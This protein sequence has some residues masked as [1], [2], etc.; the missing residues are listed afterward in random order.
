MQKEWSNHITLRDQRVK[1][2][3]SMK[4]HKLQKSSPEVQKYHVLAQ[5]QELIQNWIIASFYQK[6]TPTH[7][8]LGK[9][10]IPELAKT[11]IRLFSSSKLA[12]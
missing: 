5:M 11:P 6:K 3:K 2:S 1:D 10:H 9:V 4:K 8:C 7:S 12:N